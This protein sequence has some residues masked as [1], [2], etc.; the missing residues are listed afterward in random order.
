MR[1]L[2]GHG[3]VSALLC[4]ALQLSRTT[5]VFFSWFLA[6]FSE[7]KTVLRQEFNPV[8]FICECLDNDSTNRF[9]SC[10]V[11]T[12]RS[13]RENCCGWRERTRRFWR[14]LW[15]GSRSMITRNG[16]RNGRRIRRTWTALLSTPRTG[17]KKIG[18]VLQQKICFRKPPKHDTRTKNAPLSFAFKTRIHSLVKIYWSVS[19]LVHPK[20]ILWHTKVPRIHV[21]QKKAI[22]VIGQKITTR[23]NYFPTFSFVPRGMLRQ[24]ILHFVRTVGKSSEWQT[25]GQETG[26]EENKGR[27]VATK[28]RRFLLAQLKHGR[29]A[30]KR[31]QGRQRGRAGR[32]TQEG[33]RG[34]ER[35]CRG[36]P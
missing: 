3:R 20:F 2:I 21:R 30:T 8:T 11:W 15:P 29:W 27:G 24:F 26:Q 34:S 23:N 14:E 18:C 13:G 1:F 9:H 5:K 31:R 35:R 25:K 4:F 19:F 16:S 10:T 36:Q 7:E 6:F 28:L 22:N 17:G 32:G 12:E 33:R